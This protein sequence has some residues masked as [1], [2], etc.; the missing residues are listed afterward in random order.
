MHGHE[1]DA[2][3]ACVKSRNGYAI[4]VDNI[5]ELWKSKLQNETT[6]LNV[7]SGITAM[8]RRCR[9]LFDLFRLKISPTVSFSGMARR[10]IIYPRK[11]HN[12]QIGLEFIFFDLITLIERSFIVRYKYYDKS[13]I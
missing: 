3:P 1:K 6:I 10:F 9:G 7:E 4:T 13:Y 2:D 5:P 11:S 12:S 8:A